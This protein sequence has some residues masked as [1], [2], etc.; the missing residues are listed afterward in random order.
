MAS[1]LVGGQVVSV[2]FLFHIS[3]V[4]SCSLLTIHPLAPLRYEPAYDSPIWFL[5][6]WHVIFFRRQKTALHGETFLLTC[7]GLTTESLR[8]FLDECVEGAAL[9]RADKSHSKS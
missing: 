7:I 8:C 6:G 5:H 3:D 1:K 9:K 2:I 4:A